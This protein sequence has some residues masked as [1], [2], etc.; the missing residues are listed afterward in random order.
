[1]TTEIGTIGREAAAEVW[2]GMTVTDIVEGTETIV[3]EAGVAVL[4]LITPEAE[5]EVVMMMS[6]EA[7][8]GQWEVPLLL[9]AVQVLEGV[10]PLV[11]FLRQK[12]I[13]LIG[14]VM[15]SLHLL[16]VLHQLVVL[17]C[18]VAHPLEILM[19]MNEAGSL[20]GNLF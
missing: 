16:E 12:V 11:R 10:C 17:L 15:E 13:A 2:T 20:P 14:V 6:D 18:L 1:M 5:A 4:V 19:L 7:A 8:A 3:D 9:G